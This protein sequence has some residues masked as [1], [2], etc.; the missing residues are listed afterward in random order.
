MGWFNANRALNQIRRFLSRF[1]T[2]ISN[3]NRNVRPSY[4][5][6]CFSF[7]SIVQA[8][9]MC[10]YNVQIKGPKGRIFFKRSILGVPNDYTYFVVSNVEETFEIRQNQ[11]YENASHIYFNLDIVIIRGED[12]LVRNT[13]GSNHIHTFCE[14][15]H[16]STFYPSTCAQ[17]IGLARMIMPRNI[18][19]YPTNHPYPPPALLVS[20]NSSQR[21]NDIV[22]LVRQRRYHVRFFESIPL[23][24][25]PTLTNWK[26]ITRF[27]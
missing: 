1:S 2:L 8:Y 10:G 21:V 26:N 5:F 12:A 27:R 17:F 4:I 14:C 16:Y 15:K 19:W 3:L 18:L 9:D 25:I 20:G 11:G 13:L 7:I 22:N 23:T 6:E 24:A